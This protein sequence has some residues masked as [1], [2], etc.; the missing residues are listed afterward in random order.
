MTT[1]PFHVLLLAG[2]SKSGQTSLF[3]DNDSN[4]SD[5]L[6]SRNKFQ[7][8]APHYQVVKTCDVVS[9]THKAPKELELS[10]AICCE[11]IKTSRGPTVTIF[12]ANYLTSE[13]FHHDSVANNKSNM[14]SILRLGRE[15]HFAKL[16]L[17]YCPK[18]AVGQ[19]A[20]A[21]A[22]LQRTVDWELSNVDTRASFG[23]TKYLKRTR[24][25]LFSGGMKLVALWL[26]DS[27]TVVPASSHNRKPGRQYFPHVSSPTGS[28][29]LPLLHFLKFIPFDKN[30]VV[31][32][33]IHKSIRRLKKALNA[34]VEGLDPSSLEQEVH[35]IAGGLSVG[36]VITAVNT[37][38]TLWSKSAAEKILNGSSVDS[39]FPQL[40]TKIQRRFGDLSKFQKEGPRPPWLPKIGVWGAAAPPWKSNSSHTTAPE[41]DTD[42]TELARKRKGTVLVQT[43]IHKKIHKQRRKHVSWSVHPTDS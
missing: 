36:K 23:N 20:L 15:G 2:G 9:Q 1:P 16:L 30:L 18:K 32:S 10:M 14:S 29:L 11:L 37:V 5:Y 22:V 40:Q 7:E 12:P 27:F 17:M 3:T 35:P 8:R 6:F 38:M 24:S 13:Q 42:R 25:F 34:L 33:Q 41:S 26:V 39:S 21:L 31:T 19:R 4:S 43:S 28:L